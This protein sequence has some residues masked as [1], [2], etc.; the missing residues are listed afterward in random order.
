MLGVP[1]G[2]GEEGIPQFAL[3]GR[4][5]QLNLARFDQ[6][7]VPVGDLA[8]GRGRGSQFHAG[9]G[10]VDPDD[11][12]AVSPGDDGVAG[13]VVGDAQSVDLFVSA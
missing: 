7:L 12:E 2:F 3:Y 4:D 8:R 10:H 5:H 1:L 11:L 9:F 13:L 6:D